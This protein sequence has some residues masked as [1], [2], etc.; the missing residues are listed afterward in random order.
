MK[1][2]KKLLQAV[3]KAGGS[4]TKPG[5]DGFA[6]QVP[7]LTKELA[8]YLCIVV[9]W[10]MDWDHVSAHA[11]TPNQKQFIPF[12]EDMCYI[13]NLFFKKSE[14]VV[15]YHPPSNVYVNN[16]ECVL[17]LWRPQNQEIQLP[18]IWMV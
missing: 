13:K 18:P 7:R 6:C 14:N 9:S 5:E 2:R 10:H 1:K 16:H 11:R 15:Q 8:Y 12:W 3:K 4:I 17:H